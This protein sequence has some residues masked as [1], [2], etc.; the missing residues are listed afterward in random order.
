MPEVQVDSLSLSKPEHCAGLVPDHAGQSCTTRAQQGSPGAAAVGGESKGSSA[1]LQLS[2]VVL[3]TIPSPPCP[4]S[5]LAVQEGKERVKKSKGRV[6]KINTRNPQKCPGTEEIEM[7]EG[8]CAC[9]LEMS[10]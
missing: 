10:G 3:S 6:M 5:G 1:E 7:P 9:K 8:V 4:T 2:L